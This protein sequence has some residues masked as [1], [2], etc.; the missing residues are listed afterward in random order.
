[1]A[2]LS[3]NLALACLAALAAV[4]PP[5]G[6]AAAA[7]LAPVTVEAPHYGDVLFHVYQ[8][9][10]YDAIVRSEAYRA[11]GLLGPHEGDAE[12]LLG[13][14]YLSFG[15]HARAAEVFQRLLDKPS[16]PPAVRGRAWFQLGKTL[17]ARGYHG[18]SGEALRHA[19]G[20]LPPEM[21][22]ERRVLLAQG[23]MELGRFDE[24]ARELADWTGPE[25][26]RSFG[27]YNLGVALIRAGRLDQGLAVLEGVAAAE[28]PT[29]ELAALRD[30]ANVAIGYSSL[31][32]DRPAAARVALERVRLDGPQSSKALLGAGWAAAG[33][34]RFEEALVPWTEL[35]GRGLL[36]AAVQESYLAVPYAYARLTAERQ[37]ALSY[38][39]AIAAFDGEQRRIAESIEAIRNGRMLAALQEGGAA[40]DGG[41]VPALALPTDAPESRYLYHLM[42]GHEFQEAWKDFRTL[43]WFESGLVQ[44]SEEIE[45]FAELVAAR[46]ERLA[47]TV[48]VL[49]SRLQRGELDAAERR[50]ASLRAWL[51]RAR[52]DGDW[53]LL[54]AGDEQRQLAALAGVEAR[55]AGAAGDPSLDDLREKARMQR[56]VLQW[57]LESSGKER[58]WRIDRGLRSVERQLS[59]ARQR[60]LRVNEALEAEP[61]RSERFAGQIE[62]LRP[63]IAAL[64]G[65]L[66]VAKRRQA[67]FLASLAIAE[68]DTQ[69][70]RLAEYSA[71]ARYS[72]AALYDR[73]SAAGGRAGPEAQP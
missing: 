3:R 49:T 28:A 40:V 57:T 61:G 35:R 15:Q 4:A 42:A 48:P 72:L 36:D 73:G 63:R 37:A 41:R 2:G 69:R 17:Y 52:N 71:Q 53:T 29:E 13:G 55:L 33:E 70:Q 9:D 58:A 6:H 22:A 59:E 38:E 23:L 60:N 16:T 26:W 50:D 54:A 14:L 46:R 62:S 65:R 19:A 8:D 12:L 1:M 68:L 20:L 10:W 30:K 27:R 25:D 43:Q 56:G 18:E 31:Q 47:I 44:R 11:A 21:E 34:G 32:A 24:A 39:V 45:A 7:A 67:E 64:S 66:E 51:D 5:C